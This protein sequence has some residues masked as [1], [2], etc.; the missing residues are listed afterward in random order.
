[1]CYVE[2]PSKEAAENFVKRD[3]QY[4]GENLKL[5][6]KATHLASLKEEREQKKKE[7]KSEQEREKAEKAAAKADEVRLSII[8]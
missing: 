5:A 6:L 8:L 7:K 2:L 4:K 3:M 1:M